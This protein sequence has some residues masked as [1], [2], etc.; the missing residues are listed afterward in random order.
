MTFIW[1]LLVY[2]SPHPPSFLSFFFLFIFTIVYPGKMSISEELEEAL[3]RRVDL[4]FTEIQTAF[5][6]CFLTVL[7]SRVARRSS[8]ALE[9]PICFCFSM[10]WGVCVCVDACAYIHV[11]V[12]MCTHKCAEIFSS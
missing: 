11:F 4:Q 6:K 2:S 3:E 1:I 7:C 12:Y 9:S 8:T 10:I 5:S